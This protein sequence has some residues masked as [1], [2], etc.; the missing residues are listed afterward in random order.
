MNRPSWQRLRRGTAVIT[1]FV[2]IGASA[3]G[4][5]ARE[6]ADSTGYLIGFDLPSQNQ[7]RWG[8]E[9]K[10][11]E[12]Q[13]K[14]NGDRV[15]V[16]YA[17]Y[18]TSKQTSDVETMLQQG[19]DV[20][21]LSPV[22]STA[23]AALVTRAQAQGVKVI[24]Y[25]AGVDGATADYAIERNNYEAG[26]LHVESALN[27]V[28]EGNYAIIRGDKSTSVAQG[29]GKAY[30]E[31]LLTN[32]DVRIVYDQWTPGWESAQAQKNAEAALLNNNDIDAFVVSW[33]DGAQGV[34]QALKAAGVPADRVYVT[35]TDA[36][37]PSLANIASGWQSETVWTPI[38]DGALAA[39]DIGHA[40]ASGQDIPAPDDVVDDVK[41]D[42]LDLI[43][44]DKENLCDFITNVA[45]DGW[46]S[47]QQVYG[48][49]DTSCV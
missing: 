14:K 48:A 39:A 27:A 12:E 34:V 33:D 7:A 28:P 13:A 43:S 15:I 22:D 19:V 31:L 25:D 44:V 11:F 6:D 24:T 16:N 26:K 21:V 18:S 38:D 42:Y 17:N 37:V 49:E 8:F 5:S 36:G 23:A 2:A 1:V 35:G 32:P 9:A 10:I 47:S 40:L 45:P 41:T 20:L 3:A 46:A 4:C 29:M 30:D